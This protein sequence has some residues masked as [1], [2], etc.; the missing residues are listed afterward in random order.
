VEQVREQTAE[1]ASERYT[2]KP[3]DDRCR[4]LAHLRLRDPQAPARP[5]LSSASIIR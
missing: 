3:A 1:D 4:W 5:G 2:P